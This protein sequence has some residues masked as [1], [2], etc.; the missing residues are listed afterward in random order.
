MPLQQPS[1]APWVTAACTDSRA[2]AAA[3]SGAAP[4]DLAP[5]PAKRPPPRIRNRGIDPITSVSGAAADVLNSP[6]RTRLR[7]PTTRAQHSSS[8]PQPLNRVIGTFRPPRRQDRHRHLSAFSAVATS[9]S[10]TRAF[11]DSATSQLS[12]VV[13]RELRRISRV[14]LRTASTERHTAPDMRRYSKIRASRRSRAEPS[15]TSSKPPAQAGAEFH[16]GDACHVEVD[17]ADE[18]AGDSGCRDQSITADRGPSALPA[19]SRA[20]IPRKPAVFSSRQTTAGARTLPVAVHQSRKGASRMLRSLMAER[21]RYQ[22]RPRG[23][24]LASVRRS[25]ANSRLKPNPGYSW[26]TLSRTASGISL[27]RR[28][29]T[30]TA[31]PADRR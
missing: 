26:M 7:G 9:E 13:G 30:S 21:C 17:T 25:P 27:L 12:S 19:K 5:R 6:P 8:T 28:P 18:L 23:T 20:P 2:G 16:F 10:S 29:N 1:A 3:R 31:A 15:P 11:F 22:A 4:A 14:F 24:C